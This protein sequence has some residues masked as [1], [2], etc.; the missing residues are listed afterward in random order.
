[1]MRRGVTLIFTIFL[2]V[3]FSSVTAMII[4]LSSTTADTTNQIYLYNQA[5]LQAR[6]GIEIA[7]LMIQNRDKSKN[8]LEELSVIDDEK[9]FNTT[10][11][12]S[13]VGDYWV[14][15][16]TKNLFKTTSSESNGS[17]LIDVYVKHIS[18]DRTI[19]HRKS[20]QKP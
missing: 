9:D 17:L 3:L 2:L 7:I 12:I 5:K 16:G 14:N 18:S 20:P 10:M 1:M 11:Y 6:S 4:S 19:F 15:C 13:Y 8:C